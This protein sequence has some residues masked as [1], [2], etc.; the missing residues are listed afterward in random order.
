MD[1]RTTIINACV[2][3]LREFGYPDCDDE[4]ILTDEVYGMFFISQLKDYKS[5]S[6]TMREDYKIKVNEVCDALIQE[7]EA[8]LS[9]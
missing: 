6:E 8:N 1:I 7:I 5:Q 9:N 3:S 4:N 2:E